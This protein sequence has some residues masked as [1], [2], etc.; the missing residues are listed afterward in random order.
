MGRLIGA[1]FLLPFLWFLAKGWIGPGLRGRLWAIFGARR[2]AGRGRLVD[3]RVGPDRARRGLAVSAGDASDP[4]LRDL[5]R[6][7]VDRRAA[8]AARAPIEAPPRIRASAIALLA[9]VLVQIYLGAL[10]AGLRAGLIYNT[11]PLIDGSFIP[12]AA[13]LLHRHAAVAEFVR[14]HADG[15][16][17]SPHGGLCAAG[18]SRCCMRS[19]SR[20]RCGA[21][22]R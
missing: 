15:A 16:V 2:A 7:A 8:C 21:A 5:R 12:D 11:W 4:R 6:D 17:Q 14:E 22:R 1:A 10:V 13:R 19:M 20:G 9:L 18:C 3:G